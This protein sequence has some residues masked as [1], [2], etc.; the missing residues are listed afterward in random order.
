[1]KKLIVFVFSVVLLGSC[2]KKGCMD[3]KS[4]NYS[5]EA[6]KDDGSCI[7]IIGDWQGGYKANGAIRKAMTFF[8]DGNLTTD[9]YGTVSYSYNSS[10]FSVSTPQST[11]QGGPYTYTISENGDTLTFT[12]APAYFTEYFAGPDDTWYGGPVYGDKWIRQ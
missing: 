2:A 7:S 1:M 9:D 6:E 8:D 4:V 5:Q 3:I 12:S 10:S 11:F